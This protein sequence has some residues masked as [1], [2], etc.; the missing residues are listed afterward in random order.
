ME[1]R[2]SPEGEI[3]PEEAAYIAA[4]AERT[5]CER[6]VITELEARLLGESG[7][8]ESWEFLELVDPRRV[9]LAE[10][11]PTA[12]QRQQAFEAAELFRRIMVEDMKCG[13]CYDPTLLRLDFSAFP[14]DL[15]EGI[16]LTE[17]AA[18]NARRLYG[19]Y[20]IRAAYPEVSDVYATTFA[21]HVVLTQAIKSDKDGIM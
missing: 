13:R 9:F 6:A 16:D 10:E 17:V 12:G 19:L 2:R 4:D 20:R 11:P 14:A 5:L 7:D 21:L 15:R 18:A 1:R 3:R 8:R